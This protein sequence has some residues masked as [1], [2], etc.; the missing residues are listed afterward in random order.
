MSKRKIVD[1]EV[2][3]CYV[4]FYDVIDGGSPDQIIEK[5]EY[6]RERF[7]GRDIYFSVDSY[8]YDGGKELKLRERREENDK[9]YN[10]RLAEEAKDK[11][12]KK[13]TKAEKEAKEF[14]EYQRLQKKFQGKT[15]F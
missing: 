11:A 8:G 7:A 14:L 15:V 1:V 6:Y 13:K 10:K 12:A 2:T 5:M 3:D 4:D 9:E